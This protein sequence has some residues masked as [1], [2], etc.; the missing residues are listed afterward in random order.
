MRFS[1]APHLFFDFEGPDDRQLVPKFGW[2]VTCSNLFHDLG[3]LSAR[4]GC[5]PFPDI[6]PRFAV[7]F[8]LPRVL[9]R[10]ET[11]FEL[12]KEVVGDKFEVAKMVLVTSGFHLSIDP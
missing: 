4:K 5:A 6:F 2:N 9:P 10:F 11:R 1:G 8:E 12:W 7:C 3:A